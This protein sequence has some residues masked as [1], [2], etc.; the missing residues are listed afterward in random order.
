MGERGEH[1]DAL[2]PDGLTDGLDVAGVK[3][4]ARNSP[5]PVLIHS[6]TEDLWADPKGEFLAGVHA[7]PVYALFGAKGLETTAM[8][9]PGQAVGDRI[10]YFLRPGKH[11]VTAADWE[12]YVAFARK[13]LLTGKP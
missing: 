4:F 2:R 9:P 13:Q 7:G 8:P 5:R 10:G 11:D 6:A 3:H 12:S 1:L